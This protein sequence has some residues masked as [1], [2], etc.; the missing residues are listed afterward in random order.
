Q[1]DPRIDRLV[2]ALIVDIDENGGIASMIFARLD[3]CADEAEARQVVAQDAVD[4]RSDSGLDGGVP[5]SAD[6]DTPIL[7]EALAGITEIS[8]A[9]LRTSSKPRAP[10]PRSTASPSARA[11]GAGGTVPSPSSASSS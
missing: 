1:G 10:S 11:A 9:R 5:R 4:R 2:R 8:P 6:H 3:G 7:A